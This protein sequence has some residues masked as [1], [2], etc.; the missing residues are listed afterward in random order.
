MLWLL[1]AILL[2]PGPV[3]PGEIG[4]L[5][6]ALSA[7]SN[8]VTA[9]DRVRLEARLTNHSRTVA[10]ARQVELTAVGRP[11]HRE[12]VPALEPGESYRFSFLWP[13]QG[14]GRVIIELRAAGADAPLASLQLS[15][16]PKPP[17]RP[18]LSLEWVEFPPQGC[19]DGG[20]WT[21]QVVVRNRGRAASRPGA[22]VFSVNGRWRKETRLDALPPGQQVWLTFRWDK[23]RRGVNTV[24]AVLDAAAAQGDADS[25]DNRAVAGFKLKECRPDLVVFGLKILGPVEVGRLPLRARAMVINRGGDAVAEAEVRFLVDGEVVQTTKLIRLQPG[26]KRPVALTWMPR[27]AGAYGLTVE[28]R[29]KGDR[30]EANL[31]NN[32]MEKRFVAAEAKPDLHLRPPRLARSICL[33]DRPAPIEIEV[34]NLGRAAAPVFDLVLRSGAK[35]L[36]RRRVGPLPADS[37]IKTS[38]SWRPD[39][40]GL[41]RLAL[42]ADPERRLKDERRIDNRQIVSI[43]VRDC[44][45]DPAVIGAVANEGGTSGQA[46]PKLTFRLVNLGRRP[47]RGV[48]I[49]F[50]ID[51]REVERRTIELLPPGQTLDVSFDRPPV[52]TGRRRVEVV[53]DPDRTLDEIRRD[54]NAARLTLYP[55]PPGVD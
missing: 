3:W 21:A 37:S 25:T 36:A 44:R 39:R 14:R 12:A 4:A 50:R 30:P 34:A 8:R 42:V 11:I 51:G 38:L 40:P 55:T 7:G 1:A 2:A 32:S 47:A 53:I 28:V 9:G 15:L 27:E 48:A 46:P 52:T 10:P 26:H 20:P 16:V 22:V 41:Y 13:A 18:D 54:N 24:S 29:V 33:S 35:E 31:A 17:P 23:V 49:G 45:P 5:R 19:L 6:A 43:S